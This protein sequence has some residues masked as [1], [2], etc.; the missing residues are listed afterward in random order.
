MTTGAVGFGVPSPR[1]SNALLSGGH[2]PLPNVQHANCRF[3]A[4]PNATGDPSTLQIQF[5]DST[6][7]ILQRPT[8]RLFFGLRPGIAWE[9]V[10]A[11]VEQLNRLVA[12]MG[13]T[14]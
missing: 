6:L 12:T 7:P 3:E 14:R 10:D 8:Q 1:H 4:M 5:I 13:V 11:L 2:C 9:D